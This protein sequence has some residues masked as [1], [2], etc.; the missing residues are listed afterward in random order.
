[1]ATEQAIKQ[2][3]AVLSANYPDH[4][5][6]LN[7]EQLRN[8]RDLYQQALADLDDET[9]RA[10][11]LRHISSSQWFPKV[12]ELRE[13]AVRVTHQPA[14]DPMEAWETVRLA[15]SKYGSYGIP[16]HDEV[17][18][19]WGYKTPTFDDPLTDKLVRQ[20]GWRNLCLSEE[21]EA[22]S[23]RARF[24]DA[25]ARQAGSAHKQS[26]L[27]DGLR[28]GALGYPLL[29]AGTAQSVIARLAEAKRVS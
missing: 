29:E 13:A 22:M 4:V 5:N 12:S 20:M 19:A 27:P 23:D 6:K 18:G 8:L 17:T 2:V 15:I 14:I 26:V 21:A 25:Y 28:D 24:L 9:L 1:L 3:L 16:V 7:V 10:A 11:A